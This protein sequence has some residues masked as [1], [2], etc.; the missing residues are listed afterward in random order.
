[1]RRSGGRVPAAGWAAKQGATGEG[2]GWG[3]PAGGSRGGG[4]AP[5][6]ASCGGGQLLHGEAGGQGSIW[7]RQKPG[8]SHFT[9]GWLVGSHSIPGVGQ[10]QQLQ[11]GSP[12]TTKACSTVPCKCA[13]ELVAT[14]TMCSAVATS[15]R[16]SHR[17]VGH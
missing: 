4:G 6:E 7:G 3:V 15:A 14:P 11:C 12:V 9:G 16:L 10:R 1:M 2:E 13:E 17:G 8:V 5:L